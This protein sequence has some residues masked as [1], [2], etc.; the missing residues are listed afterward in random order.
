MLQ[1]D[2]FPDEKTRK[3]EGIGQDIVLDVDIVPEMSKKVM[4]MYDNFNQLHFD[5]FVS[6]PAHFKPLYDLTYNVFGQQI[7]TYNFVEQEVSPIKLKSDKKD[8]FLAFSGGLDSCYQAIRLKE[9]GYVVHLF[10]VKGV[11][12]Y[13]GGTQLNA[14]ESFAQKLKMPIIYA[15][16]K[17]KGKK[18]E[19][20]YYQIWGDNA[21]K[22]QFIE[23]IMIDL[24]KQYG[25]NKIS[26]GDDND[27]SIYDSD[28]KLGINITDCREIQNA[29]LL[30][31]NKYCECLE[32]IY[33]GK[34][35]N[36]KNPNKYD[37]I[38]KLNDYGCTDDYYSCVGAGRFNRYNHNLCERKYGIKL[39]QYNCGCYC[40]KCAIYNL[41]MHYIGNVEYSSPF[42]DKCWERLWQTKFGNFSEL[43]GKNIP[44]D[45]RIQNL[46]NYG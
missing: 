32:Y 30:G 4:Q 24:C 29:F 27:L 15:T 16:W 18:G 17:R 28:A 42:I 38:K 43:F 2:L 3:I 6:I 21:I 5:E 9:K 33:I 36:C 41:A 37:R 45:K 31:I 35:D 7:P 1:F 8:V 19:N 46:V 25:F 10:H 40:T 14:V 12:A 11:N 44:L 22:N 39:H 34:G 26:V 23:A 20:K 13:E